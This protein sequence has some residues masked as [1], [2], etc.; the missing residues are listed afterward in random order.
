MPANLTLKINNLNQKLNFY[1][2]KLHILFKN[3]FEGKTK[4]LKSLGQMLEAYSFKK[5]LERGFSVIKSEE[6]KVIDS[7][8]EFL[9]NKKIHV[10]FKDGEVFYE[11]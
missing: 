7:Q 10:I 3:S 6:G 11:K 4:H 5:T 8:K 2:S 1:D 9:K